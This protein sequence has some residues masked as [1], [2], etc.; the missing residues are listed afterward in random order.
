MA[1]DVIASRSHP[2]A[3]NAA[4]DG[5]GFAGPLSDGPHILPLVTG[6]AAAGVPFDGVVPKGHAIRILT[7]ANLPA[8]VDTV[9][10]QEDVNAAVDRIAING[11]LRKG[12]NARNA[13]ED[14]VAGDPILRA[15]RHLTP[16]DLG[17]ISAAGVGQ[18]S[19]HKRLRVGVLSTGDE[20]REAG[21]DAGPGDI[22]D[23]N[24]PMLRAIAARWGYEVVD[25]GHAP[26]DR[27]ILRDMLNYA[28]AR[29]DV[30]LTS[31]GASAGDEDHMSALLQDSG[32]FAL[33]RIAIKP[34][35]PLALGLWHGT[36]V[37]GLP[38]NPVAAFVC[39]LVFARPALCVMSGGGWA[40]P[41][42]YQVPAA[43]TK[44]KKS[45]AAG[46]FTCADEGRQSRGVPF[47]RV[48]PCLGA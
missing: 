39:A 9:A 34:G 20:L 30:I 27:A 16:A 29:C 10:L 1:A 40:A 41:D 33:W 7:G 35:R 2:P 37:F 43:F 19:V 13:G 5:Y 36:P 4:V 23:A 8:S 31:G 6:R 14:M 26:D 3:P 42:T 12:A 17:T 38:G 22:Y 28:A 15:G 46:I 44:S 11:P 18:V 32:T 48:W 45:R 24:R 21:A 25:L 47:R